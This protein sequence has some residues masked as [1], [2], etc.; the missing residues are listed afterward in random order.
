M[1]TLNFG[2]GL[3]PHITARKV[4][5]P[6]AEDEFA[7]GKWDHNGGGYGLP[8]RMEYGG[9]GGPGGGLAVGGGGGGGGMAQGSR[10][11]ID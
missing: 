1:C 10:M 5:D 3:K 11:T 6:H 2:R 8:P 7:G 4:N 9:G